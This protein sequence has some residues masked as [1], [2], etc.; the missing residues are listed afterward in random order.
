MRSAPSRSASDPSLGDN[1]Q[2]KS[3]LH[4]ATGSLANPLPRGASDGLLELMRYQPP[5]VSLSALSSRNPERPYPHLIHIFAR[6]MDDNKLAPNEA[7]T[8]RRVLGAGRY[9]IRVENHSILPGPAL[10]V[11]LQ[12]VS[13]QKDGTLTHEAIVDTSDMVRPMPYDII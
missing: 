2:R 12:V 3:V 4:P 6:H 10:S 11:V 5:S 9:L 1:P 7:L 13:S 8:L